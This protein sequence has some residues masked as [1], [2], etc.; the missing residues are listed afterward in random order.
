MKSFNISLPTSW[1][2]LSDKQ[3]L[4]VFE[5]FARDLSAAEV[6]TLCLMKWNRLKVLCQLP[7]KRFIIKKKG[8]HEVTLSARQMQQATTVLDFLDSFAPVPVRISRIGRHKAI[9]ADFE[10][11][12]ILGHRDLPNVHK[13]CPCFDAKAGVFTTKW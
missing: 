4:L 11:A 1:A 3:L 5:L 13:D 9:A 2:E 12:R 10:K 8:E 6:K 7:D